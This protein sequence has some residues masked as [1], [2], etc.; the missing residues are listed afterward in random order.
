MSALSG[1][2]LSAL[3]ASLRAKRADASV[4]GVHAPD[5]WQGASEL[6][7]GNE[8][9]TVAVC[10]TP[11]AVS[12]ALSERPEASPMAVL[13][14][15]TEAD[16]TQ[17]ILVR[18]PRRE[19]VRLKPWEL[20]QDRFRAKQLDP[21]LIK[22]T[23]M[24]ECLLRLEPLG[25][26]PPSPAGILSLDSAWDQV[27]K[28]E[29]G[30]STGRPDAAMVLAW[31]LDPLAMARYGALEPEVRA[32]IRSR[33]AE[34]AGPLGNVLGAALEGASRD[35][36]IAIGCVC[37]VLFASQAM[38]EPDGIRAQGRLESQIGDAALTPEMAKQWAVAAIGLLD[39]L[40]ETQARTTLQ[41]AEWLLADLKAEGFASLSSVL[42]MGF[43]ARLGLFADRLEAAATGKSPASDV[44]S[45]LQ[46]VEAHRD[47]RLH[48]ERLERLKMA[49]RLAR[50]VERNPSVA[51]SASLSQAASRYRSE[52]SF[53]DWARS[54]LIG[55]DEHAGVSKAI[56]VLLKAV[57]SRREAQNREFA[58][59][60]ADWN[61][62]PTAS[63]DLMPIEQALT[64][65]MAPLAEQA[66]LL[67]VV[68]DGMSMAVF[69]PV[70]ESVERA[71]WCE[72]GDPQ[73]RRFPM[74]LTTLPSVTEC[75]RSSLLSGS[76]KL[77]KSA[78]EKS[79][80]ETHPDLV[81]LA[82]SA[83]PL[84]FHKAQI[85]DSAEF[86]L[87]PDLRA[88]ISDRRRRVVG[89]VLNAVDDH[90]AKSDQVRLR[91][92]LDQFRDLDAL[93]HEARQA[94]RI[95]VLTSDHGHILE[96][97]TALLPGDG[98]ER[99]KSGGVA[100]ADGE[101]EVRGPRIQ[102]LLGRPDMLAP[103]SE[104]VRYAAKKNGY[105]GGATP[106]EM[107]VPVGVFGAGVLVSEEALA[108]KP[109]PSDVRPSW[110]SE[111]EP[112]VPAVPAAK[113]A[114]K[115]VLDPTAL[116]LF[117]PFAAPLDSVSWVEALLQSSVYAHQKAR[118]GKAG[119]AE[120]GMRKLLAALDKA[121]FAMPRS[122]LGQA[123]ALS[124]LRLR[125]CL[126]AA[127]KLV[128][129]EGFR[130][131]DLDEAAQIVTLDLPLLKK[132]FQLP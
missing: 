25:G 54:Q 47:A 125:G 96:D 5:G 51:A 1:P 45:L 26:Y 69:R 115:A 38:A 89:V 109:L 53:V 4:I 81:R 67:V 105:H 31:S 52:E 46:E 95:V 118:A 117:A 64:G 34:T 107:L 11:L 121:N 123:L 68:L 13:T 59:L 91:W 55:G 21:R 116:P 78:D 19:L 33:F 16:L 132:Q 17:D 84:L 108:F 9:W 57:K 127:M 83:P 93:L 58:C 41:H 88:A 10:E 119:L 71:G 43:H 32:A 18:F 106:Q 12:V 129:V 28:L 122:Q 94:G 39:D 76:L 35:K 72:L 63:P 77:G 87:A 130:I 36:L 80:F 50:Y 102:A 42:S 128:N 86:G 23:W 100:P 30:L 74:L 56:S 124:E 73:G 97:G 113:P 24:A 62:A 20:V 98:A 112:V 8:T 111:W 2:Q 22:H 29:L 48:A 15:L 3:I 114:K 44:A 6:R 27:L 101:L 110:W 70:Q 92:R 126:T 40:S 131:L 7:V 120:D 65:L 49:V 90:L 79:A 14:R 66:P 103:W 85:Q 61:L 99:W 75:G 82:P 60:L 104:G 37:E